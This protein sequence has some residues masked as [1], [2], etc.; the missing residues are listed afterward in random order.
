MSD[1][2]YYISNFTVKATSQVMNVISTVLRFDVVELW[3]IENGHPTCVY[4]HAEK[5]VLL[6]N[7]AIITADTFYP[8]SSRKHRISPVLCELARGSSTRHHWRVADYTHVDKNNKPVLYTDH[9]VPFQTEMAYH[10]DL[11]DYPGDL[12]ILAFAIG[13]VPFSETRLK[14]LNGV[15]YAVCVAAFDLADIDDISGASAGSEAAVDPAINKQLDNAAVKRKPGSAAAL[16]SPD[17][18]PVS[19]G[20]KKAFVFNVNDIPKQRDLLEIPFKDLKGLTHLADGSHSNVFLG[21]W[22]SKKV[23]VKIMKESSTENN[24]ANSEYD[25][26]LALLSRLAHP[27]LTNILGHGSHPRKFLVLEYLSGG[28]LSSILEA[29]EMKSGSFKMFHKPTFTYQMLLVRARELASAMHY[30]HHGVRDGATIIHRDLK[31]D[32][33]G[34]TDDGTLKV[35]DFGLCTCVKVRRR[36]DIFYEMT[37]NTGS[38]RYMAPEVAMRKPYGEKVDVHSYGIILWQMARDRVPFDGMDANAFM[39]AVVRNKER[40]KLDKSWP[41]PFSHLIVS[42]WSHVPTA[43]PSF[44]EIII[45]LDGLLGINTPAESQATDGVARAGIIRTDGGNVKKGASG[46]F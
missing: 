32:N 45:V 6:L 41:E 5:D 31:P 20:Q 8:S 33:I 11:H 40:P 46:W 39:T 1:A 15:S 17:V 4:I 36:S 10:V 30:L 42:C 24:V 12:F 13:S 14:F 18:C 19:P 37:G 27:N 2:E 35:L 7:S 44:R 22:N 16:V 28:I 26:E 25:L 29:N 38:L 34:F 9:P 43:R 21:T 23:V 3:K